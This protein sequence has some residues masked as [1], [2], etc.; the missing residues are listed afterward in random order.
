MLSNCSN[1]GIDTVGVL[2][3]YRPLI[4]NSHIGMGS[5]WDLDRINGGVYVLQPFMNEKKEIGIMVQHMRYIKIW[6]L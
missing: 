1:S 6:T 4:L 2:T 3:Q 5:H